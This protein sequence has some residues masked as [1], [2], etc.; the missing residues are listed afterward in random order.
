[1]ELQP[2]HV[3]GLVALGN[4]YQRSGDSKKA[5][6]VL[7]GAVNLDANNGF[8]RRNLGAMLAKLER[9]DEAEI[10]LRAAYELMPQDQASV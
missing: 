1:M 8:A 2:N 10:H 4:A 5:V 3:N 6:K 7:E 9:T